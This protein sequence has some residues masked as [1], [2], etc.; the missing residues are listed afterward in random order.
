MNLVILESGR[1]GL[2]LRFRVLGIISIGLVLVD[3]MLVFSC[4]GLGLDCTKAAEC[5]RIET[6]Q[7]NNSTELS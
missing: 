6:I 5:R 2:I 3:F 1:P 7:K 4:S